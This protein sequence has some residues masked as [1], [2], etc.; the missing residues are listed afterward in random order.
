[1]NEK[2]FAKEHEH[3]TVFHPATIVQI[4]GNGWIKIKW[5]W[6]GFSPGSMSKVHER[7]IRDDNHLG[8]HYIH[9][10]TM[11]TTFV[12]IVLQLEGTIYMSGCHSGIPPPLKLHINAVYMLTL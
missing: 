7:W 6:E 11:I 3:T 4:L 12:L 10:I 1:M 9:I 5:D 8:Q 2:I